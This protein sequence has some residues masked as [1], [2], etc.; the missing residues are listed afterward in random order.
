MYKSE[1][2][3]VGRGDVA[4]NQGIIRV[5]QVAVAV[6]KPGTILA[7]PKTEKSRRTIDLPEVTVQALA[8]H[9]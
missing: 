3:G 7:E 5:S 2:L 4:L 6:Y 1:L 9:L 8:E